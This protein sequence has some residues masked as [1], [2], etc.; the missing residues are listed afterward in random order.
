MSTLLE[1]TAFVETSPTP[2]VSFILSVNCASTSVL[3]II[4]VFDILVVEFVLVTLYPNFV[5]SF[6]TFVKAAAEPVPFSNSIIISDASFL[7]I[8]VVSVSFAGSL[9]SFSTF[10]VSVS[11]SSKF[12][13]TSSSVPYS[14]SINSA[15]S[16]LFA[17]KNHN[18]YDG[19]DDGPY[20]PPGITALCIEFISTFIAYGT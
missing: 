1:L 9:S 4:F 10:G 12:S 6:F 3:F 8:S 7:L 20:E 16:F 13:T 18:G 14:Y 15:V 5:N 19:V 11:C 17:M 2:N